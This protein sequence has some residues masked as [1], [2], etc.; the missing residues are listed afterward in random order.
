MPS[1]LFIEAI[2]YN[3]RNKHKMGDIKIINKYG[4]EMDIRAKDLYNGN[5]K[6][7]IRGFLR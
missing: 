4:K 3:I 7:K 5:Y 1:H 6:K 2:E